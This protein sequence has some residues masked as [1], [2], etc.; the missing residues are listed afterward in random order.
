MTRRTNHSPVTYREVQRLT[1]LW[2]W[3]LM[4]VPTALIWWGFVQQVALN[5]PWGDRPVS[6][7]SLTIIW[8]LT[9]IVLPLLLAAVNLS[10][11]VQG[12]V[13]R[14]R[15]FPLWRKTIRLAD[16][17]ECTARTYRPIREYGG[18]GIRWAPRNGWAY[19]VRGN[20]G[21]QLVLANGKRLLIGSERAEDLA[22]AID[23]R[24]HTRS[25][26]ASR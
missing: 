14:L 1:Q 4:L 20:R 9:G 26:G 13:I 23:A 18:W 6:D 10:T 7:L 17:A 16:I 21:V 15:Y 3:A 24:R 11:V 5:R 19:N 12:D 8:L 2:I 25:G 22:A